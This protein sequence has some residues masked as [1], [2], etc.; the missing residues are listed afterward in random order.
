MSL[1][2]MVEIP[3]PFEGAQGMLEAKRKS[4]MPANAGIQCG[5]VRAKTQN[6]DSR[7]SPR[8]I[9]PKPY[10]GFA[11]KTEGEVDFQSTL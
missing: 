11:G 2:G 6:L 10:G 4:V 8:L 9:R 7:F 5:G 3:R 1:S